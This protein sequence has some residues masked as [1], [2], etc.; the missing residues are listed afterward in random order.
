MKLKGRERRTED[1]FAF[2]GDIPGRMLHKSSKQ[3]VDFL[4][5]DISKKGMGLLLKPCP[6][7]GE[8]LLVEFSENAAESLRFTVRHIYEGAS[9]SIEGFE[10][11]KRCGV[12]LV[13]D[14]Q[15]EFDLIEIF[16]R[17]ATAI[18]SD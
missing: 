8:E 16:T 11:M 6:A 5:I 3:V 12:E 17:Y 2:Y 4:P 9:A 10:D 13:P 18:V 15:S 14:Q 1:R 7:E